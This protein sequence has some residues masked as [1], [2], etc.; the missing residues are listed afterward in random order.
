MKIYKTLKQIEADV[1]DG[2]LTVEEDVK[3][4]VSFKIEARLK[5]AGNISAWNISARDISAWDI[6]AWHIS[7]RNISARN[8]SAWNIS[9]WDISAQNI[10]FF[11]VAF[12]YVSFK[13]KKIVGQR[14]N[15]KYFCLDKEVEITR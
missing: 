12:A 11:A 5:I 8:I 2:V 3:F 14:T 13:C 15:S 1:K 4:E 9:A 6:S 10:S 7:A